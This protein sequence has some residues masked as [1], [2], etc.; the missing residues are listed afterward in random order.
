MNAITKPDMGAL[1][2]AS[3]PGLGA[4]LTPS[5]YAEMAVA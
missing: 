4:L 1:V 2:V 5:V 3:S